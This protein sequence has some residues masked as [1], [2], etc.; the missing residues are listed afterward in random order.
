MI[1]IMSWREHWFWKCASISVDHP[2]LFGIVGQ[3]S[4][5]GTKRLIDPVTMKVVN[6]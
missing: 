4:F 2:E 3:P 6:R 5:F 1:A